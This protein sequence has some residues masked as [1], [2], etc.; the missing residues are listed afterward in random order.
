MERRYF[1]LSNLF[2]ASRILLTLPMG[3]CLLTE[4]PSHRIWT[5]GIIIIAVATDFLDGYL[6]RKL[7]QVTEFGKLLDPVADKIGIGVYAILLA[8]TGDVP[9]W[10][11]ST[12]VGRDILIFA[13]GLYIHR[14]KNIIPQSNWPGKISVSCIAVTF[15]LA[16][17]NIES[18]QVLTVISLW[19]SVLLI[20]WSLWSYAQRLFIGRHI[21]ILK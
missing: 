10:F 13:G 11:I 14:K 19:L 8:I 1:T 4:F 15:F 20:V 9:F 12:V 18:L 3:Y 5:A 7:H 6:A 16:T 2:S 21:T 17:V